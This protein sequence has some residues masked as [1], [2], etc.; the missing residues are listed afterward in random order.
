MDD[1]VKFVQPAARW[2]IVIVDSNSIRIVNAVCTMH[3][4][5]GEDVTSNENI[6]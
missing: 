6:I 1:M 4:I 5:L 3:E 2:K